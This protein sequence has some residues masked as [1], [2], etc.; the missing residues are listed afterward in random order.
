MR[1]SISEKELGF[2]SKL[3]L[4]QKYFFTRD[5]IKAYFTSINE[6]NVYLYRLKKKERIIKLN[7]SK[8]FL[9]PVRAVGSKWSEHPFILIDEMMDGEDY[10]I[11]GKAAA[12]YWKLTDQIPY[13]YEVYNTKKHEVVKIFHIRMYFKKRRKKNIPRNVKGAIYGHGFMIA[14]K[15]ES[16][17][18]K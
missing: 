6:M 13:E 14:S 9:I 18:W 16:G 17:K 5:D 11:V 2:I 7:K 1:K 10:C 3:E 4:K 8:Y 12:Y 15:K